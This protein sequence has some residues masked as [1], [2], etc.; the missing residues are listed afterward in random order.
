[1]IA[2]TSTRGGS[3]LPVE[4]EIRTQTQ[5]S[6]F[7]RYALIAR[8][9]TRLGNLPIQEPK[10]GWQVLEVTPAGMV[11]HEALDH[12]EYF[13]YGSEMADGS[14]LYVA[15]DTEALEDLRETIKN[16][17]LWGGGITVGLALLGG[18]RGK[19]AFPVAHRAHQYRRP[20]HYGWQGRRAGP[21]GT[22]SRRV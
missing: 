15:Q 18:T 17:F 2:E 6:R 20:A 21:D 3:A 19:L 12:A 13:I 16:A 8:D 10:L 22:R 9:G 5:T 1:M 14:R 4:V 11:G 7:F